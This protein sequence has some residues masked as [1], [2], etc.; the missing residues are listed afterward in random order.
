MTLS[1]F[2]FPDVSKE[3]EWSGERFVVGRTGDIEFEHYHRYLFAAQFCAGKEVLDIACGEGYGSVL[4]SQVAASVF[5][6]DVAAEVVALATANYAAPGRRFEV[7]SC[8]AIPAPDHS[9]DVV[10]SFE[11]IEHIAEHEEFLAEIRRVLRPGGIAIIST[12]DRPIYSP[13]GSPPNPFHVRELTQAEFTELMQAGFT[14]L[15]MG[16]QKA[17]AGSFMMPVDGGGGPIEVFRRVDARSFEASAH[18][19]A[20]PYLVAVA[21]DA[22]LPEPRWGL[23][24]DAIFLRAI[25]VRVMD[26]EARLNSEVGRLGAEIIRLSDAYSERQV[27]VQRLNLAYAEVTAGRAEVSAHLAEV[28]ARLAEVGARLKETREAAM[29]READLTGE[30][31]D[32][33]GRLQAVMTSTSWKLTRPVRLIKRALFDGAEGRSQLLSRVSRQPSMSPAAAPAIEGPRNATASAVPAPPPAAPPPVVHTDLRPLLL[34]VTHDCSRTGAPV[35]ALNLAKEIS[36]RGE[37]RLVC[38]ARSSGEL[39]MDFSQ[40]A[41]LHVLDARGQDQTEHEVLRRILAGL[42]ARPVTAFCNTIVTSALLPVFSEAGIPVVSL[43]HELP[44][45][46]ATFGEQTILTI[47]KIATDVVYGSD[48]VRRRVETA[49]GPFTARQHVIPTGYPSPLKPG[50]EAPAARTR[51]EQL[52]GLPAEALIVMG[53]GTLDHRKGPDLFVQVAALIARHPTGAAAHFVWIGHGPD[54]AYLSWLRH[55]AEHLGIGDRVHFL[56]AVDDVDLLIP[57]ADVFLLSSR[58]DPYPLVNLAAIGSGVP[59][60]AFEGA[61]GAPEAIRDDAGAVVPYQDVQAMAQAALTMLG[62][63]AMRR[64]LGEAGKARFRAEYAIDIFTDRLMALVPGR[65]EGQS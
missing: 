34:I 32:L 22:P 3:L 14:H 31:N 46:I 56:G 17:T 15:R 19:A 30:I 1:I 53:C 12:P 63:E 59:S 57:G 36:R 50:Y 11:T 26:G 41:P 18:L 58:E 6:V 16:A 23:L 40:I 4:L 35:V 8:L 65:E 13:P 37:Y 9:V 39:A 47:Q 60:I 21:S 49:F 51:I 61:G 43:V 25:Q 20:A 28:S 64:R 5:G 38:I 54:S 44:T 7:G 10:V 24:D 62:D 45:S 2:T 27:E 33:R 55:D 48:Y 42:G 52:T 29:R